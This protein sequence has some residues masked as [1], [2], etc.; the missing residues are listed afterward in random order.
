MIAQRQ[1][2]QLR[3]QLLG[4]RKR[5][6]CGQARRGLLQVPWGA[7]L[8]ELQGII[9][10]REALLTLWTVEVRTGQGHL[11]DHGVHRARRRGSGR[12]ETLTVGTQQG[13]LVQDLRMPLGHQ[14]FGDLARQLLASGKHRVRQVLQAGHII[15]HVGLHAI[16]PTVQVGM[17]LLTGSGFGKGL[18]GFL[19]GDYGC[20]GHREL[21]HR[22]GK[23]VSCLATLPQWNPPEAYL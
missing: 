22:W 1:A 2:R 12:Q 20:H 18:S 9:Q 23:R 6:L 10:G 11:A 7:T 15:G 21:L 4:R 16:Q 8:G 5:H 13:A 19:K 3:E 14:G 17:Q